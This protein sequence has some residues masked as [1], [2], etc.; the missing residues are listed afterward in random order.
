V[1]FLQVQRVFTAERCLASGSYL[2]CY[3]EFGDTFHDFLAPNKSTV[4]RLANRFSDT[5]NVQDRNS[6]VCIRHEGKREQASLNAVDFS[7][8]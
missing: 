7:S 8:T 3:S 6:S 5:G 2:T 4:S 1:F